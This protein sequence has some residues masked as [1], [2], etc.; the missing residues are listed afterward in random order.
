[1]SAETRSDMTD[2]EMAL[3]SRFAEMPAPDLL[4][5]STLLPDVHRSYRRDRRRLAA[6]LISTVLIVAVVST[7][8]LAGLPFRSDKAARPVPV[9]PVDEGVVQQL[10]SMAVPSWFR[11]FNSVPSSGP[12]RAYALDGS[13]TFVVYE[14]KAHGLRGLANGSVAHVIGEPVVPNELPADTDY[15]HVD[16]VGGMGGSLSPTTPAMSLGLSWPNTGQMF[17]IW[18]WL[19]DQT[20]RIT[21]T[22]A[23]HVVVTSNVIDGVGAAWVPHWQNATGHLGTVRAFDREGHVL[24]SKT[25]P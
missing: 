20:V 24:V 6:T 5:P 2:V 3:R 17:F 14:G 25:L 1:M 16:T 13:P 18:A 19:P 4:V 9:T 15:S 12:A 21:Y 8:S 22:V 7:L 11:A 10:R 23:G